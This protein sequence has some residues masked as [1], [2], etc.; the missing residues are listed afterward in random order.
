ML[1]ILWFGNISPI[2]TIVNSETRCCLPDVRSFCRDSDFI[3]IYFSLNQTNPSPINKIPRYCIRLKPNCI[4]AF[5]SW[6]LKVVL[7]E[8]LR[9]V[10]G[11][12]S[13]VMLLWFRDA[14]IL[15]MH[16]FSLSFPHVG[17]HA[18]LSFLRFAC[19]SSLPFN[20]NV[21]TTYLSPSHTL[22]THTHTPASVHTSESFL[23]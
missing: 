14:L 23:S 5:V 4:E 7:I 12:L 22:H 20:C 1:I 9:F 10:H 11:Y 19:P 3:T 15:I 21:I 17:K 16:T 2:F 6:Q 18:H 13:L 8:F